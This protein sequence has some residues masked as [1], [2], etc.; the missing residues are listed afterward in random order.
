MP[1][2]ADEQ[3]RFCGS[4]DVIRMT[5]TSCANSVHAHLY[6]YACKRGDYAEQ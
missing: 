1:L 2:T 3:C 6:C 5:L 4:R